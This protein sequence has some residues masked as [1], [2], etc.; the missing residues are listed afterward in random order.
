MISSAE[1][2]ITFSLSPID[3]KN[4]FTFFA[5]T[6]IALFSAIHTNLWLQKDSLANLLGVAIN[7]ILLVYFVFVCFKI[8]NCMFALQ[9]TFV[10]TVLQQQILHY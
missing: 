8:E 3:N 9:N 5:G 2:L 7:I 4:F 6:F 1:N 10:S